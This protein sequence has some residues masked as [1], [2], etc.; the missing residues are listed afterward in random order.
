M[1]ANMDMLDHAIG[2]WNAGDLEGYLG[3]YDDKYYAN[4]VQKVP[5]KYSYF[6]GSPFGSSNYYFTL[7]SQMISRDARSSGQRESRP[8]NQSPMSY[9]GAAK[10]IRTGY[11]LHFG[12]VDVFKSIQRGGISYLAMS[13]NCGFINIQEQRKMIQSTSDMVNVPYVSAIGVAVKERDAEE[14][15]KARAEYFGARSE[16]MGIMRKHAHTLTGLTY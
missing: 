4:V 1:T 6:I 2:R 10:N 3:L 11:M 13:S 12:L 8:D 15:R 14:L 5:G 16:A 7:Q 9:R